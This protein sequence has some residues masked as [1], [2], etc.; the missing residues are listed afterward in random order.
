MLTGTTE[1]DFHPF[2]SKIEALMF[3]LINSPHP[4]VRNY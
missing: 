2:S 4:I 3:M 1:S